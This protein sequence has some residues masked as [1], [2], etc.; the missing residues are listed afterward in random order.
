MKCPNCG[1]REDTAHLCSCPYED[2][3]RL[4]CESAE[5][6]ESWM[7]KGGKTHCE[8]EYW[9]PIW[10]KCRGVRRLQDIGNMPKEMMRLARSQDIIGFRHFMEGRVSNQ[11]WMM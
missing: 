5:E 6:L 11:F 3:T 2:I 10:I 1:E 8:I 9:V 4:M 7:N